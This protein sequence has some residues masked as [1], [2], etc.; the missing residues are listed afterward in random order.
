MSLLE[1]LGASRGVIA[2]NHFTTANVKTMKMWAH[3]L[4]EGFASVQ[5]ERVIRSKTST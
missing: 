3:L 4:N 2:W 5:F 1:K